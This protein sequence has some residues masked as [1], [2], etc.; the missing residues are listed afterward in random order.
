[1]EGRALLN[2]LTHS[3]P[4]SI[5]IF[6]KK[7]SLGSLYAFTFTTLAGIPTAV[8]FAGIS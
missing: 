7:E 6:S 1:M 3:I 2:S 5:D 4:N 8:E